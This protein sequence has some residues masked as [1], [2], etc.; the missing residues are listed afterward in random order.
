MPTY[1]VQVNSTHSCDPRRSVI[2]IYLVMETSFRRNSIH[3]HS[4][5]KRH[6]IAHRH[7]MTFRFLIATNCDEIGRNATKLD[8]SRR[9]AQNRRRTFV[10]LPNCTRGTELLPKGSQKAQNCSIFRFL[11]NCTELHRIAP[12]CTESPKLLRIAE[13]RRHRKIR[14]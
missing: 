3:P 9:N 10:S 14:V 4:F 5:F 13:L 8:E 2:Y 12:N 7:K 11:P 6:R 1:I